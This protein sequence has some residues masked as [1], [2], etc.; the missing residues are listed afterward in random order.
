VV[1][2]AP[3]DFRSLQSQL[4]IVEARAGA[5]PRVL[6]DEPA[7]NLSPFW[8]PDGGR[9]FFTSSRSGLM[10]GWVIPV[11]DG[12]AQGPPAQVATQLAGALPL[13]LT[14]DGTY[15]YLLDTS[16][17]DVYSIAVDLSPGAPPTSEPPTRVSPTVVGG[18][19]GPGWSPDGRR[20][21]YITRVPSTSLNLA[22]NRGANLITIYDLATGHY[23]D[24]VPRLSAVNIA[25]PRWSP[26]GRTVAVRGLS[27]ENQTGYFAVDVTNGETVPLV[28]YSESTE[29]DYGAYQWSSDGRS[30]IYRH[31]PRG[32]V[33]REI[34]SGR[35]TTLVDWSAN[36]L[37][38]FHGLAVSPDGASLAFGAAAGR[39]PKRSVYVQTGSGPPRALFTGAPS[40]FVVVQGWTPGGDVLFTRYKAGENAAVIP[41]QMWTVSPAGGDARDT[42]LRIPG[43]TQPYFTALSPDGRR[44]AYTLGQTSAEQWVMKGFLPPS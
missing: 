5:Q 23:R 39:P 43:F 33:S 1:Y 35:E 22:L 36:G 38:G 9:V 7:H 42:S 19:A 34:S 20:L 44:L 37:S 31:A 12:V 28:V 6:L 24:V 29:S 16:D 13:A 10:A 18:R 15:H 32:I 14:A 11:D 27:L 26:D 2:D 40:E 21:A 4:M 41:H 25:A 3:R 8:T 17:L 30:L